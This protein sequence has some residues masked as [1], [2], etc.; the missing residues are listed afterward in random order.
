MYSRTKHKDR[1]HFCMSCLQNFTT[2]EIL[3]NHRERCLLINDT[4]A[5]KYETGII[6]FKNYE[7]QIPIPFKIYA[8]TECLLKRINISEGKYTKLYQKHIPN[9]IGAKLVCIDNRF[10]LPTIIF[11]GKKCIN[12]FIKW[13]FEKQKYC[14]QIITNHF[15]KNLKMIIKDENNYQNS[16]DCWICNEK[17][18]KN[19]DKVRDHCHITG[20]Y[21]DPAHKKCNLKLKIPRKL[22]IIFHNLEGYDGHLIFRELNNFKDIDIQV[23]PKTN[24]RY[25]N[26]IVNNSI[27]FLDSLQFFKESLD[28]L[29]SN[30][31]NEDFKH[32]LSEFP[33]DKLEILKRNIYI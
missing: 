21:R 22:P 23:I 1:K 25:M 15:N 7:K 3:N 27:V 11:E 20:K 17:I 30:L 19:K 4:Q 18:I 8:D 13:I 29:A 24:E 12:E 9:S 31:N 26:I 28:K 33:P 32:L 6:K 14:N 5:V 10:T 16:N 2:K